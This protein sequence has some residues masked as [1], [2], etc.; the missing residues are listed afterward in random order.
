[1]Q[2]RTL[3]DL[4]KDIALQFG[5]LVRNEVRLA[6][7]EAM[8]NV[9]DMAK[10]ATRIALGVALAA[11]AVT[12]ALFAIAYALGETLPMWASALIAAV[13]GGAVAFFLIQSGQKAL[14][15]TDLAMPRT[16]SQVS[17]DIHALK[18]MVTS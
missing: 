14:S 4:T 16:A 1:M 13:F 10:G 15:P 3:P 9:R 6:R 8:D 7:A 17:Q 12:L 11:A 18:E 5:D 2:E